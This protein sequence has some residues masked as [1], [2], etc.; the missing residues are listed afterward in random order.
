MRLPVNRNLDGVPVS[1]VEQFTVPTPAWMVVGPSSRT[2][3]NP[4]DEMVATV[5]VDELQVAL[6]VMLPLLPSENV[7][8]AVNCWVAPTGTDGLAGVREIEVSAR[9]F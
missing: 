8:V 9:T 4:G 6:A 2:V 5:V 1:V 3:V 7:P